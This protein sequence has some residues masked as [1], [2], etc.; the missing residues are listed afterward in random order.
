MFA[1][2]K[3]INRVGLETYQFSNKILVDSSPPIP[4]VVVELS[5]EL[6]YDSGGNLIDESITCQNA[7]GKIYKYSLLHLNFLASLNTI[8]YIALS[9]DN[10]GTNLYTVY[11]MT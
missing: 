8:D 9:F 7:S 4:G 1:T 10:N 5:Q 6:V 11:R 3:A 2:V